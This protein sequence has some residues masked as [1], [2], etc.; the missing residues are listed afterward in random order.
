MKVSGDWL[1]HAGTQG[2]CAALESAGYRAFF[3]GGC[4]R[5]ALLGE[6]VADVD[7]ATDASPENVTNIAENAGFKV[8]PTGFDHGTVTVIA[9][10]KPHEVTTF[11]RDVETDGRRAVVAF[12]TDIAED[13]ARRDF[14]M[15][16]LYA[17]RQGTLIDPLNGLVDLQARHV[18][19]VGDP[20]TRIREDY[21]RILRFFR[22]HACYGDPAQGLDA[23]ALAACA[24][25]S[26]GL[27]TISKER[28]GA[29]MRKLLS[30]P[31]PAPAVASMAAAG[32]LAQI[33]PGADPRALAPLVH[34][35]GDTPPRWLRRL[36][37]MGGEDP[38]TALRL[39]RP[40]SRDLAT[41]RD[42]IG[43]LHTPAAL[44]WQL[45]ADLGL[46]AILARAATLG[47]PPP[48]GWQADVTRGA[49]AAFP[50]TAADL[51]P[52]LQGP[53]LGQRLKA[54]EAKWLAS[55]LTLSR[56]DLLKGA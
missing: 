48:E 33:L 35:E 34:L 45:G 55:N 44:G 27:E 54:L 9:A 5:N 20:E 52:A 25:F 46:D 24:A 32:V 40:E 39:S 30:A 42:A 38:E 19:F 50:V 3:V 21:L 26:A 2:L 1:T 16:A 12:S 18:R 15:N 8:V 51:M 56:E 37:V 4:V 43:S 22:F 17:D 13:A 10:G 14:T 28:I 53:A 47:T 31:D 23:E 49:G 41:L 7:L 36:A 11:R 6:P 29:E